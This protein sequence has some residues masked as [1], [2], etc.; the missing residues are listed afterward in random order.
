MM[1]WLENEIKSKRSEL[2]TQE[3][4]LDRMWAG[5]EPQL[6]KPV[7]QLNWQR[8]LTVAAAAC[9][10]FAVGYFMSEK[11]G[12]VDV[13]ETEEVMNIA[14]VDPELGREETMLVLE[15]QERQMKLAEYTLDDEDLNI[16]FYELSQIDSL[17]HELRLNIGKV[18]NQ[19][20]LLQA[21]L[22]NYKKRIRIVD[23]MIRD[24]EKKERRENRK[25]GSYV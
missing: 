17:D 2:D 22:D 21:L 8:W 5:I 19:K 16:F 14:D 9:F 3:P 20:K 24:I 6:T 15:F 12:S 7:R 25:K 13:A 4:N 23:Q 1:N 18:K 10:I 11:S